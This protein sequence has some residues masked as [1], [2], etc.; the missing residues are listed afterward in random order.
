MTVVLTAADKSQETLTLYA[1][2]DGLYPARVSGRDVL[3][4]LP[5]ATVAELRAKLAAIR[6]AKPEQEETAMP[7]AETKPGTDTGAGS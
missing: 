7:T 3:F 1:E 6:T 4:L 2:K 5:A